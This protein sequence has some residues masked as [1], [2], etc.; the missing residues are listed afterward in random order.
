MSDP[1][2]SMIQLDIS[3]VNQSIYQN[4]DFNDFDTHKSNTYSFVRPFMV[5][6]L[7]IDRIIAFTKSEFIKDFHV[8]LIDDD[9]LVEV[10]ILLNKKSE[11]D[12]SRAKQV[13][14][15]FCEIMEL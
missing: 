8:R 7:R 14:E 4:Q 3:F 9:E 10:L 11:D 6:D 5:E 15:H 2:T 12:P 1:I 13:F